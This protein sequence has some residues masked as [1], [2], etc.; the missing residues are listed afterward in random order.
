MLNKEALLGIKLKT[1]TVELSEG[2]V[3]IREF[4]TSDREKFELL[5]L[6]AQEGQ[7]KNLKAQ[8]IVISLVNENGSRVFGDDEVDKISQMPSTVTEKLF[9]SILELNSMNSDAVEVAEGN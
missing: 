3:I 7:A 9:N 2:S 4:T 1:N 5:A 8:L 6:K